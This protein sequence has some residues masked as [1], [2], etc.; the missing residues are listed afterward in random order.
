MMFDG[1]SPI[2]NSIWVTSGEKPTYMNIGTTIGAISAHWAEP[3]VM[4]RFTS[5]TRIT[6]APKSSSGG[7]SAFC[8]SS[9]P[10]MAVQEPRLEAVNQARNCDTA[11]NSTIIG[12]RVFRPRAMNSGTSLAFVMDLMPRP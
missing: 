5:A 11:K 4:K 9:E 3:E 6:K 12:S 7:R 10:L 8:S 2:R 1:E